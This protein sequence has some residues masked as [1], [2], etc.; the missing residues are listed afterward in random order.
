MAAP[1]ALALGA[2]DASKLLIESFPRGNKEFLVAYCFEGRIAHQTLGMLLTRRM[3][4]AGLEAARLRRHRLRARHLGARRADPG[5]GRALFDED[6]LGDDLEEWLDDSSMLRARFRNVA[7]IAGLI[8]RRHPGEEKSRP[9]GHLQRRP[10]L[11]RAAQARARPHPAARDAPGRG[12]E[13]RRRAAPGRLPEAHPGPD[14]SARALDR[15]TPLA[16][17]VLITLGSTEVGNEAMD[18]LLEEAAADLIEEATRGEPGQRGDVVRTCKRARP[19]PPSSWSCLAR[20]STSLLAA[21]RACGQK[22]VDG[23]TK[24]DHDGLWSR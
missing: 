17:P 22:L 8:E 18:A 10:D 19:I 23:R 3:E 16:V 2:A 7:V 4:R 20:P 5:A 11:R 6:M 1:A 14:R 9:A 15:V 12:V 21:A 24:S 13:P